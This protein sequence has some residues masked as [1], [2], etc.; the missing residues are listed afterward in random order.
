MRQPAEQNPKAII[1]AV[2]AERAE[3]FLEWLAGL[4]REHTR[5]AYRRAVKDFQKT[6][7]VGLWEARPSHFVSWRGHLQ[8]RYSPATVNQRL[9]ALS[10]FYAYVLEIH[11]GVIDNNPV[12]AA[13]RQSISPYG[14][15]TFLREDQDK[16]LLASIPREGLDGYRDFAIVYLA[17]TTAIR[18]DGVAQARIGDVINQGGIIFL[19]YV[20]KGGAIDRKRL[21]GNAW[22]NI[23]EYL[24][25]R[26][27]PGDDEFLFDIGG[28]NASA[29]RRAIQRMIRRRC[30]VA[31][32]KGHGITFHS[33][34]HTAA[35][36]A[37]QNGATALEVSSMLRHKDLRITTIYLQHIDK[38]AGDKASSILDERYS[39][40]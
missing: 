7:G 24:W 35:M 29:R 21:P 25:M 34:R 23:L 22:A 20:N 4:K 11:P 32:G 9:S 27:Y 38:S 12:D 10:S 16:R 40:K 33:L 26:G 1:A 18:L 13:K 37:I 28:E 17:L 6:M 2:Q 30:D 31:F 14:R 36:N 19:E 3:L 39:K 8:A 15:A 5:I